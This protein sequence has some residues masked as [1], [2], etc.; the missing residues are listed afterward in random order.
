M[1]EVGIVMEPSPRYTAPLAKRVEELGFDILLCPDT[2]NLA[3]D[4]YGQ[5]SLAAASTTRLKLGTGVTNPITREAAVTASALASLNR[6]SGGRA[7]CGIGRGDS[8][9][10]H[11][12]KSNATTKQLRTYIEQVRAYTH[13]EEVQVGEKTSKLRWLEPDDPRPAPIDVACT[14]PKTIELEVDVGDR[15]RCAV[16]SPVSRIK[17]AIETALAR[18][19]STG[20]RRDSLSIGA[21]VIV[22]C[23]D[24]ERQ[25]LNLARMISGMVAHFAGMKNSPTDHLPPQLRPLAEKLKSGYDMAK[26]AQQDG[27]HLEM[28][29]D[30]FVDWFAICGGPAKCLERLA[31]L[32]SLGLDHFY[33]LGGSPVAHPHGPRQE[34]LVA[35]SELFA[36]HVLPELRKI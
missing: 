33:I 24:D 21:Y 3:G 19:E 5:L 30:E 7:I 22:V 26:H 32:R 6:E 13:G 25:A 29:N 36:E 27:S 11:I 34:A 17:W 4:P 12:G 35:Q 20:R 2:Q 16:G 8:S 31:E 9:A 18:L 23:D 28:V 14:G 15:I 10:A 1:T